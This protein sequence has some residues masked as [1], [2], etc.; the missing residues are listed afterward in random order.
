[1]IIAVFAIFIAIPSV[2]EIVKLGVMALIAN[3]PAGPPGCME[4]SAFLLL[5]KWVGH[6]MNFVMR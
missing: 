6:I 1:M 3:L 4:I 5:T 2:C